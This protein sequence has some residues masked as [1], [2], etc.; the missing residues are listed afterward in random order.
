MCSP[1]IV[2]G[3]K[4]TTHHAQ[5]RRYSSYRVPSEGGLVCSCASAGNEKHERQREN[6]AARYDRFMPIP[7]E[8]YLRCNK[9]ETRCNPFLIARGMTA[10]L[11]SFYA[12]LP[13]NRV[14]QRHVFIPPALRHYSLP[15]RIPALPD[16]ADGRETTSPKPGRILGCLAD[17][18]GLL[19]G[20]AAT[21]LP[22]RALADALRLP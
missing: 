8:S 19:S 6:I 16:R 4:R 13:P 17:L 15:R 11:F 5:V 14:T 18:P 10:P 7:L 21:R 3:R 20:R 1:R 9:D 12:S 22:L 2:I